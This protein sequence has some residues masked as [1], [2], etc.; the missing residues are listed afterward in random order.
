MGWSEERIEAKADEI[1]KKDENGKIMID[2]INSF[3]FYY[4]KNLAELPINIVIRKS[5][6][7]I[8]STWSWTIPL[9]TTCKSR[10]TKNYITLLERDIIREA[11]NILDVDTCIAMEKYLQSKLCVEI[12]KGEHWIEFMGSKDLAHFLIDNELK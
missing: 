7:E 9:D 2:G 11:A 4:T 6:L 3:Y 8:L 10:L 5:V 1:R 12:R